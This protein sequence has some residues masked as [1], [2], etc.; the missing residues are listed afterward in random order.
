MLAPIPP[1]FRDTPVE[2]PHEDHLHPHDLV[3][4]PLPRPVGSA[5][6]AIDRFS[7]VLIDVDTDDGVARHR[8]CGLR[9][10]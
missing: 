9:T 4:A 5:S 3:L 1:A 7:V 2:F 6:G 10:D 8:L